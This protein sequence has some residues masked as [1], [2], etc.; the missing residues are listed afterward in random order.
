VPDGEDGEMDDPCFIEILVSDC[1]AL[2][3]GQV[4]RSTLLLVTAMHCANF[5]SDLSPDSIAPSFPG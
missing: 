2:G 3:T 5:I 1:I 4:A